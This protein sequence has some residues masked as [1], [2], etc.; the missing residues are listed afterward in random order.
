MGSGGPRKAEGE[1]SKSKGKP[2]VEDIYTKYTDPRLPPEGHSKIDVDTARVISGNPHLKTRVELFY[3]SAVLQRQ[4]LGLICANIPRKRN[5]IGQDEEASES[6]EEEEEERKKKRRRSTKRRKSVQDECVLWMG[7]LTKRGDIAACRIWLP[8]VYDPWITYTNRVMVYCF[9]D[10]TDPKPHDKMHQM[11]FY[12]LV[13]DPKKPFA[14]RCG[15]PRCVRLSHVVYRPDDPWLKRGARKKSKRKRRRPSAGRQRF[16]PVRSPSASEFSATEEEEEEEEQEEQ[17]EEEKDKGEE[18][19]A[20]SASERTEEESVGFKA[21][22]EGQGQEEEEEEE[23]EEEEAAESSAFSETEAEKF[24]EE[25]EE[26]RLAAAEPELAEG[27]GEGEAI[28]PPEA[29]Q[30]LEEEPAAGEIPTEP[31]EV[32]KEGPAAAAAAAAE[33]KEDLS[34]SGFSEEVTTQAPCLLLLLLLVLSHPPWRL[35]PSLLRRSL[36]CRCRCSAKRRAL[37]QRRHRH[38]EKRCPLHW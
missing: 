25:A 29:P 4:L 2:T 12:A 10:L 37:R 6:E 8:E 3:P 23:A 21:I 27:E 38:N 17:E 15:N 16:V 32:A 13:G 35:L 28:V 5:P 36:H 20:F 31:V 34:V 30:G 26:E 19:S 14:M 7:P 18:L 33:T 9:G 1:K 22:E 24:P 11:P